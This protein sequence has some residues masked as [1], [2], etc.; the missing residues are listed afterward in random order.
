MTEKAYMNWYMKQKNNKKKKDAAGILFVCSGE[1]LLGLRSQNV[2]N[3]GTWA[4]PGGKQSKSDEDFWA[5]AQSETIEEIGCMPEDFALIRRIKN[6]N[7]KS[8]RAFVTFVLE[9]TDEFKK[10]VVASFSANDEFTDL[11]WFS[12]YNLP[13]HMHEKTLKVVKR[14][15]KKLGE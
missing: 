14:Y 10:S 9:V 13:D 2:N 12:L 7:K 3:S 8:G 11:Q 4:V 5:T 6:I 1:I 15:S